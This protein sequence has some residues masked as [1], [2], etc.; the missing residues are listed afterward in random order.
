MRSTTL[1]LA[2]AMVLALGACRNEPLPEPTRDRPNFLVIVADD[3]GYSDIGAY[4]GEIPTPNLDKLAERGTIAANF[5]VAPRGAPTRAMLLTG[6]DNHAAG[7]G[8]SRARLAPNQEGKPGYEGT[9]APRV[10]TVA[11]LLQ[12]AGYHT[13]MAGT[14]G[15]GAEPHSLPHARGFERTFVLHDGAASYFS[16]MRSAI[17]GRERAYYTRDGEPVTELP[18]D[19][20]S[21]RY[22]TDFV[23]DG[24][25]EQRADDRP[26]FAYV[27]YQAPHGPY[28]LPDDWLDR[29]KGRYDEGYDRVG[30]RRLVHLKMKKL[31]REEVRPYP[32][33]PTVPSWGS[34]S[35]EQQKRQSRKMELYAALV[36]NL[37][38]HIGRLIAYLE[39]TDEL[40][41]TA[42]VFLSD[43]GAEPANRGPNGMEERDREAYAKQ[44]PLTD[45]E[46]WGKPGSF[47]EY[48]PAW[49]QVSMVPFRLFKGTLAEGGIRAPIIFS[50]V[51]VKR[52]AGPDHELLHVMDIPATMLAVA[53]VEHP[54]SFA[55]RPVVPLEGTS[56]LSLRRGLFV[57]EA[58]HEWIGMEFAGD[59]A[60]RKG[61]W[62]MVWMEPPFGA[63]SWRLYRIDRD[64]SELYDKAAAEPEKK[65]ELEALWQQYADAHGVVVPVA[66]KPDDESAAETVAPR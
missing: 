57:K 58:P 18:D 61:R 48:G 27:A 66:E 23:I 41:N 35:E 42:I 7:F 37:D 39:E 10:V 4:G 16:D 13:L 36:E 33:I 46:D 9:L 34:L 65:A 47:V 45:I 56:W 6:V 19:Y 25:E 38:F 52:K 15:L 50:G 24:I 20:Y 43:N 22:F 12:Q 14:W 30:Q 55:G 8:T 3:L 32:G 62:K 49:A 29:A 11:S 2:A 64:P 31:V 63:G 51:S 54:T 59:R 60:L 5:Y 26:F 21:T 1:L 53:G 44:F 17:P 28:H 40:R